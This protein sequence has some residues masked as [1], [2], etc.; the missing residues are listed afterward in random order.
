MVESREQV[1]GAQ[2]GGRGDD[3]VI[4]TSST[5]Q[6]PSIK[7]TLERRISSQFSGTYGKEGGGGR[8]E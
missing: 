8:G 3:D 6:L 5:S 7:P 4:K 1:T 2:G